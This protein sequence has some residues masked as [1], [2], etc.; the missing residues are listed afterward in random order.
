MNQTPE[1]TRKPEK[2]RHVRQ[3]DIAKLLGIDRATVTRALLNDPAIAE[4]TR[5]SVRETADRL[6]YIPNSLG[7]ALATG[8]HPVIGLVMF[9]GFY[10]GIDGIAQAL[11]GSEWST[12]LFITT[13]NET[14]QQETVRQVFEK[15]VAGVIY[16]AW[17]S[18][19][20][21]QICGA[22]MIRARHC[23]LV[24]EGMPADIPGYTTVTFDFHQGIVDALAHLKAQGHSRVG[25]VYNALEMWPRVF[26]AAAAEVGVTP[27][28]MRLPVEG[29]M[30]E[31][32]WLLDTVWTGPQRP[33]A[34][35]L[36]SV[37]LAIQFDRYRWQRKLNIPGD[38]SPIMV[39][40]HTV[41]IPLLHED[42]P[43]LIFDDTLSARKAAEVL[44]EMI[45][46]HDDSPRAVL[47]PG[48]LRLPAEIR[49]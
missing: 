38:I 34:L 33:T 5:K 30:E 20:T 47:V 40:F 36:S 6:G 28:V 43:Y 18:Q 1:D 12:Q 24:L 39:Q 41:W 2:M 7:R 23:P 46:T 8:H 31:M 9:G 14:E 11:A 27:S 22:E 3:V 49:S 10:F 17:F 19:T 25:L 4:A 48:R 45:N 37:P 16:H 15:R 21:E 26:A 44:L 13:S 32:A 35:L 42:Y 29:R